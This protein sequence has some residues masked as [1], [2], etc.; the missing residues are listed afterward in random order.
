MS[1][2]KAEHGGT[3]QNTSSDPTNPI[4]GQVWW[5]TTTNTLKVRAGTLA[6]VW[7]TAAALNLGRGEAAGAG[8][9]Q[10]SALY[11]AGS[12]GSKDE[13]ESWNGSSWTEVGDLNTARYAPGGAGESN[14]AALCF[15]GYGTPPF[16]NH[17][18]TWN[19]TSWTEVNN[20]NTPKV[21][22][23][24]GAGAKD[25]ALCIFGN[26]PPNNYVAEC[27]SWNGTS[28][29]E[30]GD[31][32]RGGNYRS[33][34]QSGITNTAGLAF[35]GNSLPPNNNNALCEQWN[36]SSWTEVGDLNYTIQ[37]QGGA[38]TSTATAAFGGNRNASGPAGPPFSTTGITELWNGTAWT[39]GNDLNVANT[40]RQGAGTSTSALAMGGAGDSDATEEYSQAAVGAWVTGG[41]MNTARD[42]I[43]G[44]GTQIAGIAF[45]GKVTSRGGFVFETTIGYHFWT[46][47]LEFQ[48]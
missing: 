33:V 40:R 18:E 15:G 27:E 24:P 8:H 11:F 4:E 9:V 47:P 36:G 41:A 12:P 22:G 42:G 21:P 20:L 48:L 2:Y 31:M 13:T 23:A 7:S 5:N 6:G 44:A 14:T 16:S 37:H 28:W 43:A 1:S 3:I 19:G 46:P 25:S 10:D 32:A 38:G 35:G 30:V 34:G 29:T 45:G 39:T 17:T 26:T